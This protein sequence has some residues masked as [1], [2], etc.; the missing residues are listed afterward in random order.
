MDIDP[1]TALTIAWWHRVSADAPR[2]EC[3]RGCVH[4]ALCT[5]AA[6]WCTEAISS[7][8]AGQ[9]WMPPVEARQLREA[10]R[11]EETG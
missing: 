7:I 5:E 8:M 1:Y 10:S 6:L 2:D 9:R 3:C 11:G 4:R